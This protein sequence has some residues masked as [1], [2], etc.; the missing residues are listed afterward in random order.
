MVSGRH[1]RIVFRDGALG[2]HLDKM[3]D[4]DRRRVASRKGGCLLGVVLPRLDSL[5]GGGGID[6]R[7]GGLSIAKEEAEP[8]M[9]VGF[10]WKIVRFN[11][12]KK[13]P[14]SGFIT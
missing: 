5:P 3:M 6:M 8:G 1:A 9:A 2:V 14:V 7:R 12:C 11:W 10:L 4:V 13:Y